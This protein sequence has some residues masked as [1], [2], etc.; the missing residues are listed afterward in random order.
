MRTDTDDTPE[1]CGERLPPTRLETRRSGPYVGFGIEAD[2]EYGD[3]TPA[4]WTGALQRTLRGSW[5][6]RRGSWHA[7]R[8]S[9]RTDAGDGA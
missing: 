9:W 2:I 3:G 6:A 7:A 4:W 8:E 1:P 5:H